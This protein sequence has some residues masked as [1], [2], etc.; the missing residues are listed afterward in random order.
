MCGSDCYT[1][2]CYVGCVLFELLE[3]VG[4]ELCGDN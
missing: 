4:R 1:H 3:L 2:L